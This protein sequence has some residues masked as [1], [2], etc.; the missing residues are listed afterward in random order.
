MP[1]IAC[2]S[3][4]LALFCSLSLL[5]TGVAG[6]AEQDKPTRPPVSGL[7][8]RIAKGVRVDLAASSLTATELARLRPDYEKLK[9]RARTNTE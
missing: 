1:S 8:A 5:T 4:L 9:P 3:S 6:A 7:K 2:R